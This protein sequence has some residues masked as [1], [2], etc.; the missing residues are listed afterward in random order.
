MIT[1]QI[2]QPSVWKV[3]KAFHFH[4]LSSAILSNENTKVTEVKQN[5]RL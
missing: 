4:C 2:P 5:V 3:I 1:Y